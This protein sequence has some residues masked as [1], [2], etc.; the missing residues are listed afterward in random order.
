MSLGC[1]NAQRLPIVPRGAPSQ[2]P[3][4]FFIKL[5]SWKEAFHCSVTGNCWHPFRLFQ[6]GMQDVLA[7][8]LASCQRHSPPEVPWSPCYPWRP[9]MCQVRESTTC[10]W[11]VPTLMTGSTL[12]WWSSF[13]HNPSQYRLATM[14]LSCISGWSTLGGRSICI[15]SRKTD[16]QTLS[17]LLG[18]SLQELKLP[19]RGNQSKDQKCNTS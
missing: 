15:R 14:V 4:F 6:Q 3:R 2:W 18:G 16:G 9:S 11:A 12:L 13:G 7:I 1:R 10:P 8:W 19:A 5:V 17:I